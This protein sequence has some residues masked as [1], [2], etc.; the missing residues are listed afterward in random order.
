MRGRIPAGVAQVFL[1]SR[2]PRT[3]L[4]GDGL[5]LAEQVGGVVVVGIHGREGTV[6][7]QDR[8]DA[9]ADRLAQAGVKQHLGVVVGVHVDEAGDDPLG[10]R[11]DDVGAAGLVQR[12]TRDRGDNAV[13]DV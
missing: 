6:A 9:V 8:G 2:A 13:A 1:V 4:R 3:N 7:Q 5:H 12:L 10:R 11:V